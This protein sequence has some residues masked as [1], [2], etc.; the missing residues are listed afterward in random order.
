MQLP[1]F[2]QSSVD[3]NQLSLTI[4]AGAKTLVGVVA[5]IAVVVGVDPAAATSQYMGAVATFA[6]GTAAAYTVFQAA[7]T[8][9]GGVRKLIVFFA[10]AKWH[11][12]TNI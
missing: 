12:P 10:T 2:L 9:Y 5:L 4:T 11:L 6:T 3:P 8:L 7:E 1:S